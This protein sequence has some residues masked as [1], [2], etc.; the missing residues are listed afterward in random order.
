MPPEYLHL[1]LVEGSLTALPETDVYQLGLLLWLIAENK[2]LLRNS[3]F[4]KTAGCTTT[5]MCTERHFEP[6]K[7][8]APSEHT[9]QYLIHIINACRAEDPDQRPPACEI[10]KMFPH[11]MSDTPLAEAEGDAK[12]RRDKVGERGNGN[13]DACLK[14]SLD[15]RGS[16]SSKSP[17]QRATMLECLEMTHRPQFSCDLCG[18][19]MTER[20]FHCTICISGNYD[21]CSRCFSQGDHCLNKTHYLGEFPGGSMEQKYYTEVGDS[22]VRDVVSL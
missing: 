9:P 13:I 10:L 15:D 21:I 1:E 7:L 16:T 14:T 4:C 3:A 22:G 5:S 8:P 11:Q 17:R 2:I 19:P 18:N 6:I 12:E 20:Y